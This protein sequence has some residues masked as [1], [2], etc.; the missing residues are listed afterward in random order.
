MRAKLELQRT[1]WKGCR[2]L[3]Q[4]CSGGLLAMVSN[5][6]ALGYRPASIVDP[7]KCTGCKACALVCPEVCFT[8]WQ[9]A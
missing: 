2:L 5:I 4:V 7:E 3:V 6:N 9:V 1:C 8:I